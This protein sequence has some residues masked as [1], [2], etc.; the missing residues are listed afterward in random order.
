MAKTPFWLFSVPTQ[1]RLNIFVSICLHAA[2][3]PTPHNDGLV[4]IRFGSSRSVLDN[5]SYPPTRNGRAP[6]IP[7][8]VNS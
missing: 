4:D 6:F 1:H 5:V 7:I 8:G 2:G 3:D